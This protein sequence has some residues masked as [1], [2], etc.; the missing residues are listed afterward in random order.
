M[1]IPAGK[2]QCQEIGKPID[3]IKRVKEMGV[4]GSL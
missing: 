1:L 2:P 3:S 4:A